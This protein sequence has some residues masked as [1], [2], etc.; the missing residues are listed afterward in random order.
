MTPLNETQKL[1]LWLGIAIIVGMGLFPPWKFINESPTSFGF[2]YM[3]PS[4]VGQPPVKLDISRLMVEWS[5]VGFVTAGLIVTA[6]TAPAKNKKIAPAESVPK[7]SAKQEPPKD[8]PATGKTIKF[9]EF[10]IGEVLV[11]SQDDPEYWEGIGEARGLVKIP[12]DSNVQLEVRKEKPLNLIGLKE[13]DPHAIQSIDF[14]ESEVEDQDL[15]YLLHF[16]RLYEVDFSHTKITD[17]GVE[18]LAKVISL[19][20]IWLDNTKVTEASLDKLKALQSLVK[21]SLTGTD[22]TEASVKSIKD[23]FPKDCEII[24]ASGIPA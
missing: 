15:A 3:P 12:A 4:V 18:Q 14:S 19:K 9:P 6:Q 20:K 23:S 24:M 2:L 17:E 21:V 11:E 7:P 16:N 13:M 1:Y 22:I 5:L 10:S 8:S